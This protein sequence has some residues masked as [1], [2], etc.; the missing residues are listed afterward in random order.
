M[1][2]L[3]F[4]IFNSNLFNINSNLIN[5]FHLLM[6]HIINPLPHGPMPLLPLLCPLNPLPLLPT[7]DL[8]S[9]SHLCLILLIISLTII[10][11]L[12]Q[13]HQLLLNLTISLIH[14]IEFNIYLIQYYLCS[15]WSTGISTFNTGTETTTVTI[16]IAT[17]TLDLLV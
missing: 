12:S 10:G 15:K 4:F 1:V 13:P 2:K 7:R 6:K 14:L 9:L 3:D 8:N 11:Y 17:L 16:T 5:N